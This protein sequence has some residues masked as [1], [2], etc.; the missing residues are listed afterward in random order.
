MFFFNLNNFLIKS[1]DDMSRVINSIDSDPKLIVS[2]DQGK[3][4]ADLE[5]T[6]GQKMQ[7]TRD[8][9]IQILQVS[10]GSPFA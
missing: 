7:L 10:H 1:R 8:T 4:K 2:V 9:V 6:G 5:E 3:I